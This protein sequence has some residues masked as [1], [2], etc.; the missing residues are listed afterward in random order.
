MSHASVLQPPR[1]GKLEADKRTLQGELF[2][3]EREINESLARDYNTDLLRRTLEDFRSA[4]MALTPA[5]QADA[6]Q[7]SL[8]SVTIHPGKLTLEIFELEELHSG[9]QKREEWLPDPDDLRTIRFEFSAPFR[10][11]ADSK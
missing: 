10:M 11:H 5:E 6:L 9:S 8:Q 4:F 2:E 3:C 1:I 7:C